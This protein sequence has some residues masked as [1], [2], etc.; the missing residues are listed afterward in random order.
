M[1]V[2]MG[3]KEGRIKYNQ[4]KELRTNAIRGETYYEMLLKDPLSYLN[5]MAQ[6]VPELAVGYV[7]LSKSNK[8]GS[9]QFVTAAEFYLSDQI[10]SK[11]TAAEKQRRNVVHKQ[12]LHYFHQDN[13]NH[14]KEMMDF[15]TN[16]YESYT[17]DGV[18]T[19]DDLK[20]AKKTARKVMQVTLSAAH[21][22]VKDSFDKEKIEQA[23]KGNPPRDIKRAEAKVMMKD[24]YDQE[25]IN[26]LKEKLK[27]EIERGGSGETLS[28]LIDD[29]ERG[30]QLGD[31]LLG[32]KGLITH[33]DN[34]VGE[35][36]NFFGNSSND[37]GEV[38]GF[39]QQTARAYFDLENNQGMP[40]GDINYKIWFNKNVG[41][42]AD[43]AIPRRWGDFDP[44]G[45]IQAAVLTELP[46]KLKNI[47]NS[48][49][50]TDVM[51]AL[52]D[53]LEIHG[54]VKELESIQDNDYGK[55]MNGLV[56]YTTAR[57][58]QMHY[59]TRYPIVGALNHLGG[60][61]EISL[62]T[63]F[64]DRSS[65][66]MTSDGIRTYLNYLV[67]NGYIKA[68][69]Y[70]SKEDIEKRLG[71]EISKFAFLEVIPNTSAVVMIFLLAALIQEGLEEA[72]DKK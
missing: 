46:G 42:E 26:T 40:I 14:V 53:V 13:L 24:I 29:L 6:L 16:L 52:K 25:Y 1:A 63:M 22:K 57:Y 71:V 58:F 59:N 48:Y 44:V 8:D 49:Q 56:A 41:W 67:K 50:G 10:D 19:E 11:L 33:F 12:L 39:F 66:T 55:E 72:T 2:R 7:K 61:K 34:Y 17:K 28:E 68:K 32:G 47:A 20:E 31:L 15:H 45:K 30:K 51:A 9:D 43:A 65:F 62:A 18:K 64:G 4:Y 23:M 37:L 70:L 69:G 36:K 54:K 3:N 27:K 21:Q 5:N 35:R 60:G 38:G